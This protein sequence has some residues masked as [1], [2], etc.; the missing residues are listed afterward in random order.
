MFWI[1][2]ILSGSGLMPSLPMMWPMYLISFCANSHFFFF[3]ECQVAMFCSYEC[4]V[5][6][7]VMFFLVSTP[8]QYVVDPVVNPWY[9]AKHSFDG[10]VENLT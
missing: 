2:A 1:A 7:F 4:C 3:Q 5:Q 8:N 6:C 10:F 9:V